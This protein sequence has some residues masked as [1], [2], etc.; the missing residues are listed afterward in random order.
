[1][2]GRFRNPPRI[3]VVEVFGALGSPERTSRQAA[4]LRAL[5]KNPATRAVVLDIDSPGGTVTAS[6]YLHRSVEKLAEE[7]PAIAFIRGTGA[8]GAYLAACAATR[9]VA[10]PTAIVGSIGAIS[11]RP[12]LYDFLQRIGVRV[13]VTKSGRLKDMWSMLREPTQEERRKEQALL[14]EFYDYLLRTVARKRHLGPDT[15]GIVGTGEIFSGERAYEMGLVDVLGDFDTAVE[16]AMQLGKAPRRVV[17]ARPRRGLRALLASR[18]AASF[19]EE[20]SVQIERGL[21]GHV[22]FR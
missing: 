4:V 19:V 21:R 3:A 12:L 13:S 15:M 20:F 2:L 18:L 10:L 8:S 1:M 17:Y 11:V 5:A 7:K 16:L 22:D 14:D 6:D 9:I